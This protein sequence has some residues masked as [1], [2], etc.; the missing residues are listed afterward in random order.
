MSDC[1]KLSANPN[2]CETCEHYEV[3]RNIEENNLKAQKL[4]CYMFRDV[5]S[6]VCMQHS[7]RDPIKMMQRLAKDG[8]ESS[9]DTQLAQ[10]LFKHIF[11]K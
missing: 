9:E 5:P 8:Y 11:G 4:H 10:A 7:L 2:N 1:I 3:Q 6:D